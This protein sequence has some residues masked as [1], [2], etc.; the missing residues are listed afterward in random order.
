MTIRD[1][2]GTIGFVTDHSCYCGLKLIRLRDWRK[3]NADQ[4]A[5]AASKG[6]GSANSLRECMRCYRMRKRGEQRVDARAES[7]SSG[8]GPIQLATL[9]AR[10]RRAR[11]NA[12]PPVRIKVVNEIDWY[13]R[14][15]C[16]KPG[17][18]PEV[19]FPSRDGESA[20]KTEEARRICGDCPVRRDCLAS[21]LAE[22]A[23]TVL[24]EIWGIRAGLKPS[25]RYDLIERSRG[26]AA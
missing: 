12:P 9:R 20:G 23:G 5:E 24:E 11:K 18:D 2:T 13:E 6:A 19:F 3:M 10:E 15:E 8:T 26:R 1:E 7:R 21:S 17:V 14:A 25:E 16:R 4:R 22:E